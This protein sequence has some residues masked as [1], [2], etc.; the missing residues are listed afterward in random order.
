MNGY[1]Y[2][3]V[4]NLNNKKYIGST[5]NNYE[6]RKL[7]H[8]YRLSKNNHS[9][10]YLQDDYNKYGIENFEFIILEEVLCNNEN[11]VKEREDYWLNYYKGDLLYNI[12][13]KG[14][15]GPKGH[16]WTE[17]QRKN[18]TGENNHLKGKKLTEEH[19]SKIGRKGESNPNYNKKW[20]DEQKKKAS[21]NLKGQNKGINKSNEHKRKIS[22]SNKGKHNHSRENNPK[23]KVTEEIFLKIKEDIIFLVKGGYKH[24]EIESALSEQYNLGKITISRI[25]KGQHLF[26]EKYGSLKDWKVE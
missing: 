4:C 3:I 18:I 17:E 13:K 7:Q 22:E 20:T 19:K 9:N 6:K 2:Y 25:R 16:K 10:K 1:I 11:R 5:L 14:N 21:E 23:F 12:Y 26:S 8:F 24:N 15:I